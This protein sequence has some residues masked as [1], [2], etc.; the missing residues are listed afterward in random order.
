[1][2]LSYLQ[3]DIEVSSIISRAC[4]DVFLLVSAVLIL[5]K[6]ELVIGERTL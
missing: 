4:E 6:L 1:M 3:A 2:R 5:R